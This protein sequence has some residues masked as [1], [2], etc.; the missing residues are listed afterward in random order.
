GP[1]EKESPVKL[2]R[3]H[4]CGK[5]TEAELSHSI[6]LSGWVDRWRDHGGIVFI[7]LRDRSGICQIVFDPDSPAHSVASELRAETVISVRGTVRSRPQGMENT[8]L[9]SG[10]VE[11]ACLELEVLSRAEPLPYSLHQDQPSAGETDEALRLKYRYLELR[12]PELQRN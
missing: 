5:I 4:A 1:V 12:K 10:K 8:K 6:I 7:D 11:V 9:V 3:T 2:K